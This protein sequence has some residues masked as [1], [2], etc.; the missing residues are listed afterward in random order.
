MQSAHAL[1][2]ENIPYNYLFPMNWPI[3]GLEL[4]YVIAR[5]RNRDV[6]GGEVQKIT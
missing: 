5:N 2:S 3:T 4:R 1:S 6:I